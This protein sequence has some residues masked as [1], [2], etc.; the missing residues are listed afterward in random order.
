LF[1]AWLPV[2]FQNKRYFSQTQFLTSPYS[3]LLARQGAS[4]SQTQPAMDDYEKT[5]AREWDLNL[6]NTEK[7][8]KHGGD[9]AKPQGPPRGVHPSR[10]DSVTPGPSRQQIT[11]QH[12]NIDPH[13]SQHR[14]A[15]LRGRR[16]A[17]QTHSAWMIAEGVKRQ[18]QDNVRREQQPLLVD[19]G[20]TAVNAA[21]NAWRNHERPANSIAVPEELVWRDQKHEF[22]AKKFGTFVFGEDRNKDGMIQLD[23]WGEPAAVS[24]THRAIYD[25]KAREMPSKRAQ[26]TMPFS[27]QKSRLPQQRKGEEKKW[28]HELLRQRFR[29][30]PPTGS[31]F[32]AIGYFHWPVKDFP[33]HELLGNSYEAF[34]SIRMECSSY[35][36]FN[37][38][39]PGFEVMGDADAVEEAL[40]RI[41]KAYFQITARPIAPMRRYFLHLSEMDDVLSTHVTLE[42]YERI[43][44]IASTNTTVPQDHPGCSPKGQA[45]IDLRPE[46]ERQS[47][48]MSTRDAKTAG[49]MIMLM[50]SKL[51]YYRGHLKFRIRL[52]TFLAT[53][54]RATEDGRYTV[55]DFKEMLRQSQ[56][57]GEVTPE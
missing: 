18:K 4:P 14:H 6:Q 5:N 8:K 35:V 28:R 43:R 38:T 30:A 3:H 42:Q 12:Q 31:I 17:A 52:G 48:E 55:D 54:Y 15:A 26:G 56:F 16:P 33:P 11:H 41:R 47:H 44:R 29:R 25:W 34:D 36:V 46:E 22:F 7:S 32:G 2:N 10:Q 49:K 39:V 23:I 19:V 53:H 57:V 9:S 20:D 45:E 50:I 1:K 40:L 13:G 24:A 27:K 51:H 37:Q 21:E